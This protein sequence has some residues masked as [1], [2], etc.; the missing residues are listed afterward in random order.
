ME[1]NVT[2][3]LSVDEVLTIVT[4][5]GTY[6]NRIGQHASW[7]QRKRIPTLREQLGGA[8]TDDDRKAILKS[9]DRQ[10]K[11]IAKMIAIGA[12]CHELKERI[13]EA[14]G[15]TDDMKCGGMNDDL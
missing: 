6:Q 11:Y 14:A 3:N 2:L 9:L 10:A 4:A 7:T 12:K 15:I 8:K 1:T 13:K 5:L